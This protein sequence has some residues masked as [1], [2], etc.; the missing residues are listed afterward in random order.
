MSGYWRAPEDSAD[1]LRDGRLH[2]GDIGYMD[3]AGYFYIVDRLKELI[4][5]SGY[6]VYPRVVEEAIYQHPDVAEVAV[7]GVPGR[8]S[9]R[10]RQSLHRAARAGGVDR[11]RPAGEFLADKLSPIELTKA[12]RMARA[13]AEIRGW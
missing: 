8:L 3:E 1:A 6:N 10:G 12:D 2:T 13:S 4:I 5:C 9:G 11:G 7:C